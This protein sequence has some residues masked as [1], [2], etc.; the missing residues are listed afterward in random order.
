MVGDLFTLFVLG[1]LC[2]D[3]CMWGLLFCVCVIVC[4][5]G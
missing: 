4:D 2:S 1:V 5:F 3:L